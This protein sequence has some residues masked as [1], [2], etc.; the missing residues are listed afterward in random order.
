MTAD[1]DDLGPLKK[2]LAD[3]LAARRATAGLT[4]KALARAINYGRSTVGTAES[5]DRQPAAEFW[6]ACD[7]VLGADGDLTRAYEQLAAARQRRSEQRA[8]T[9]RAARG[10]PSGLQRSAEHDF[11]GPSAPT[12]APR[13]V[14][15]GQAAKAGREI[16]SVFGGPVDRRPVKASDE[17]QSFIEI[18]L[19]PA[20]YERQG[21][22]ED[23]LRRAVQDAWQLR[24][25]AEYEQLGRLLLAILPELGAFHESA[26]TD[27]QRA[28][29]AR[30]LVH[31]LNATSSLLKRLGDYDI[32]L[33][34]ADRAVEMS[35][36]IV[37]PLLMAAAAHRLSNVFLAAGRF[38][39]SRA[40][41]VRAADWVQPANLGS[42]QSYGMWGSLLLTAAVAAAL[43]SD[44]SGAW[45]LIGEARA[46]GRLVGSDRADVFS[47]FGPINTAI[48]GVQVA[49]A[50]GDG[51][52][53]IR[54]SGA[55]KVDRLPAYLVERRAQYLLDLTRAHVMNADYGAASETLAEADTFAPEEV[56]LNPWVRPTLSTLLSK[57][58]ASQAGRLREIEARLSI[59]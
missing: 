6:A 53:A 56:G 49:V 20:Q 34:A 3:L 45:E 26:G 15:R 57:T 16:V 4:Q 41:A 27:M 8:Q 22:P 24:Q 36:R 50:L 35:R 46:A 39:E 12:T 42:S 9:A 18:L 2:A 48:H 29:S 33:V 7:K 38:D 44:S 32:A 19:F 51:P 59:G 10:A 55:V 17:Q 58:N 25:R 14:G 13:G 23:D 1:G 47:I 54:R 40:V 5:G 28:S 11:A 30:L 43:K 21:V 37:D 52:G 31:A